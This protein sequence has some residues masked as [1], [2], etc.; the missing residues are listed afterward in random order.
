MFDA[1]VPTWRGALDVWND[2][3]FGEIMKVCLVLIAIDKSE[4]ASARIRAIEMLM[5]IGRDVRSPLRDVPDYILDNAYKRAKAVLDEFVEQ[6]LEAT[7][8][9]GE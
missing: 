2:P 3:E 8:H 9:T 4:S 6:G 5:S 1:P 7:N